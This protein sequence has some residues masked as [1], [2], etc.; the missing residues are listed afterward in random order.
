MADVAPNAELEQ[1]LGAARWEA[2]LAGRAEVDSAHLL[3]GLLHLPQSHA[4]QTLCALG[5]EPRWDRL[6][7]PVS[8]AGAWPPPPDDA[9]P[10]VPQA[11]EARRVLDRAQAEAER[12]GRET[13]GLTDLVIGLLS[14]T[15]GLGC[16]LLRAHGLTAEKA[17]RAFDDL[18]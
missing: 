13:Y 12:R 15:Q 8:D 11:R 5:V 6:R 3:L 1:A 16:L 4:V 9:A 2:H 18:D 10:S 7:G 14:E 17:R